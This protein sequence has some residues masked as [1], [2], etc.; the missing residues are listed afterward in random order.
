MIVAFDSNFLNALFN[1]NASLAG[2]QGRVRHLV[3]QIGDKNGLVII[4]APAWAELLIGLRLNVAQNDYAG[5]IEE[6]MKN[7]FFKI[8]PFDDIAAELL[9]EVTYTAHAAGDKRGGVDSVWQKIK[10]DRQ[11]VA[12]AKT[13]NAEILYTEDRDQAHFAENEFELAARDLVSLR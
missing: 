10:F 5:V 9:V 6:V 12:I 2:Y 3:R 7:P 11:I 1:V 13:H 8:M 4:P